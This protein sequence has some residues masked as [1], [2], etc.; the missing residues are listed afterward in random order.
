MCKQNEAMN[1]FLEGYNCAQ[2]VLITF[3]EELEIDKNQAAMLS[4]SFG[5]GMG[6]MHEVCGAVSAMFMVAGYKCGYSDPNATITKKEH[7]A[8]IQKLATKFK[9]EHGSIICRDLLVSL[10]DVPKERFEECLKAR[11]CGIF[12]KTAAK[13]CNEELF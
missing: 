8:L 10:K 4:S 11:P 7:Y 2:A 1:Y 12:V 6:K 5:G 9:E 13:I 3:C